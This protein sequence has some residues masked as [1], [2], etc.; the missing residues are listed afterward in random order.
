MR[1]NVR[2]VAEMKRGMMTRF[3]LPLQFAILFW[4]NFRDVSNAIDKWH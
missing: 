3:D 4:R 2:N 1:K